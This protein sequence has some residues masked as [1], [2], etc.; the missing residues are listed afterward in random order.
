MSTNPYAHFTGVPMSSD[1]IDELLETQGYGILSLCSGGEPY[2]IPISFGY[3]GEQIYF[4]LLEAGSESTKMAVI[5]D[6][7][8][9]RLLV[10]DIRG[11]FEWQSVAVT[12]PVRAL[13]GDGDQ[14][15]HF[16]ETLADNGWFMR[17]FERSSAV[18]SLHGWKL[19]VDDCQGLAQTERGEV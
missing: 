9:V 3:D 4:G 17:A 1:A 6:G 14:W 12:G 16:I 19:E 7:A 2:S 18:E 10:T 11:R 8:R 5:E 13:D 15:D